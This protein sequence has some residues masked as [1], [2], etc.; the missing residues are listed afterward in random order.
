MF[1]TTFL[2]S[3]IVMTGLAG[4]L[5]AAPAPQP[6]PLK[7]GTVDLKKCFDKQKYEY[8][9]DVGVEL[10][11]FKAG[12]DAEEAAITAKMAALIEQMRGIPDRNSQLF[13]DKQKDY[14]LEEVRKELAQRMNRVRFT[15]RYAEQTTKIYNEIRH[16]VSI[17]GQ[18]EGLD[19]VFRIEEPQLED[20][21]SNPE[22]VSQRINHRVVLYGGDRLDI[23]AKVIAR[24]NQ[25]YQKKKAAGAPKVCAKCK[26]ENPAAAEKCTC[27][28]PLPK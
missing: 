19:L 3:V 4:A 6:A 13:M 24:L 2:A 7:V 12:L 21:T 5:I 8:V 20:D 9:K 23:T 11:K 10:E 18:E 15:D 14:K 25:E 1:R 26:K 17:V 27:G 28:E 16:V 22:T